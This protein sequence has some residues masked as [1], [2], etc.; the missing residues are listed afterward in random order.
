[1]TTIKLLSLDDILEI[2]QTVCASVKQNLFVWIAIELKARWAL[3]FILVTI[4]FIM[5]VF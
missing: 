3:R 2:N 5:V 1:M 4:H